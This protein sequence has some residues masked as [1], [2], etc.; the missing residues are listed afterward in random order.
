M[1]NSLQHH[2]LY[3]P[4]NSPGQNTGVDRL[5]LLQ[6][7]FPTQV[8]SPGL[9]HCRWILYQLSHKRSPKILEWVAYPVPRGSSWLR[10]WTRVSCIAG[11]FSMNWAITQ[12]HKFSPIMILSPWKQCQT[13]QLR[14]S[15]G[16]V[17]QDGPWFKCQ[18]QLQ[19]VTCTSVSLAI[20]WRFSWLPPRFPLIP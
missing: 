17:P 11:R 14:G 12:V 2:G 1:S 20:N 3:S 4:W 7:I 13:P 10:N 16:S 6:G 5:S 9:L 18:L 19:L 15:V 8:S